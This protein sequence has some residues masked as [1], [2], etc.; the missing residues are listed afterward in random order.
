MATHVKVINDGTETYVDQYN[1]K[2]IEIP[3]KGFIRMQRRE[4]INF[5]SQMSPMDPKDRNR[6][7][8][9][10]LRLEVIDKDSKVKEKEPEKFI[11]NLDGRS[12]DTDAELQEHLKT[13]S[14]KVAVKDEAGNI[15]RKAA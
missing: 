5:L 14:D 15:K 12:F 13:L 11:C 9:K 1:G 2:R 6:L 7:V 10:I 4:A 8:P 3:V